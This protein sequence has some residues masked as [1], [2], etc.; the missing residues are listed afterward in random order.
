MRIP[1]LIGNGLYAMTN[2]R[3]S[4][5]DEYRRKQRECSHEKRDPRGMCY[6]CGH[7][8]KESK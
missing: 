3:E 1:V 8:K 4:P 5:I 7:V 2:R 6:R